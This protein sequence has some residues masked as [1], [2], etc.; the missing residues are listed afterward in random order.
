ME[1]NSSDFTSKNQ[2][3]GINEPNV[4][5]RKIMN[6]IHNNININPS[7]LKEYNEN[8]L[9]KLYHLLYNE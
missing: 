4:F 1:N 6:L 2:H 8:D 7:N 5:R 9:K 3:F